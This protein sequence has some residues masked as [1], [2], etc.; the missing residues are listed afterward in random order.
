VSFL[1]LFSS[2]LLST[3]LHFLGLGGCTG[4][5]RSARAKNTPSVKMMSSELRELKTSIAKER[6]VVVDENSITESITVFRGAR[7]FCREDE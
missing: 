3:I 7:F 6:H 4:R 5:A 1:L 2:G